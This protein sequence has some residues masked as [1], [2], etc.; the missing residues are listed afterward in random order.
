MKTTTSSRKGV[1]SVNPAT[2]ETIGF[3]KESTVAEVNKAVR[4][5]HEVQPAWEAI[6]YKERRRHLLLVRDYI[7]EHAETLAEIISRDTG[8]TKID[9]LSTEVMAAAMATTYYATHAQR[10]LKR[11]RL[12][13]GSL[14]TFNKRSYVDRVPVGVVVIISP[15]NYPFAIPFHE[16]AMALI[17]GNAVILKVASQTLLVGKAIQDAVAAGD[18]P[19]GLF[20]LVNLP[21]AVAGNAFLESDINKLFFTGSVA[22]GKKL[23]AKAAERLV[24]VSLELGGNDAMIV[25]ADANLH[26]AANG[27]LW[28]GISNAGQSCAGVERIY[29]EEPV[30]GEFVALLK[31]KMQALRQGP[32]QDCDVDVGAMTTQEQMKK[33]LDHLRDARSK[34]GKVFSNPHP[35]GAN[36]AGLFIPPTIVE[37]AND[38]MSLMREEIFGP[39]LGVAKVKDIDEA[40]RRANDSR[41]GLAA[42]VWTRNKKKAHAIAARLEAGSVMINDHLMSHGL[43]ETPWGGFKESGIGRTHGYLGLEEMTQPRVVVDDILPGLQKNM[44]WYPHGRKV[45]DGLLGG[46]RVLYG[47]SPGQRVAGFF[48]LVPVFLRSFRK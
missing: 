39:V 34:G 32:D 19:P 27:A 5:A 38:R 8:K 13:G 26:R 20:T 6:G 36:A 14:L 28:A 48:K 4:R 47:K 24:P 17:A 16:I 43:A 30:Y 9:A 42:S 1:A 11:K 15:W 18:F 22:V 40:V 31:Q 7:V 44:W 10:I 23:M 46:L 37:E 21:G 12:G 2:G 3:T 45:F 35:N 25:C 41:L 33:V 29:V